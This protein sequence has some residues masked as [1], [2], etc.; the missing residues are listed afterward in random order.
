MYIYIYIERERGDTHGTEG[1]ALRPGAEVLMLSLSVVVV[2]GGV[3]VV[4]IAIAIAIA[5]AVSLLSILSSSRLDRIERGQASGM[6]L[7]VYD[8]NKMHVNIT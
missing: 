6:Y 4:A 3:G 1:A 8:Y 2:V 7:C 5:I